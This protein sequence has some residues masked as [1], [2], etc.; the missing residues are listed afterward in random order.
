MLLSL[1]VAGASAMEPMLL[2]IGAIRLMLCPLPN[3]AYI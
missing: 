2:I 3:Y 1:K